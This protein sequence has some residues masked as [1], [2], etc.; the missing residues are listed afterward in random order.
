LA[1]LLEVAVHGAV[2]AKLLRQLVPRAASTHTEDDAVEHAPEIHPAMPFALGRIVFV[3][4]VC[5][6]GQ[7][8]SGISQM[9]GCSC[10]SELFSPI[11]IL[12]SGRRVIGTA[13]RLFD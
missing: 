3:Q 13:C 1:P 6:S 9:V 11:I 8:S 10:R 7:T 4:I 2:V 12:L 5:M